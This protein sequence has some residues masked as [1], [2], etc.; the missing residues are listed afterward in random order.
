MPRTARN[1]IGTEYRHLIIRGVG[2]QILFEDSSDYKYFLSLLEK[3]SCETN[4]TVC[5]YCLMDNHVHLL[6]SDKKCQVGKLMQKLGISYSFYYNNKYD[7]PGHL[8][9]NR[10][11]CENIDNDKYLLTVFRYILNNPEKAGICPASKY[12]WSS[13]GLYDCSSFVDTS[14]LRMIVGD[15]SSYVGF[16]SQE[17]DD[18]CM[19]YNRQ[20]HDD[21]WA[22]KV[23]QN[24]MQ[25]ANGSEIKAYDK[26]K[27]DDALR[28]LKKA[29]LSIRQIER[30]T[31]VSRNII[32][33]VIPAKDA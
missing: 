24:T 18:D 8:F 15:Y 33:R 22:I 27:R 11:K 13:Y 20:K 14:Y 6:V 10:Y 19:E 4:V 29:G 12:K 21:E 7:R 2:H 25:I 9:Q 26:R 1:L 30:L 31:G 17:N 3:Y 5:A 28:R 16:I 32:Q 23:M